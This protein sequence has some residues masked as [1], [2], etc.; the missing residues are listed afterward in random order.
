MLKRKS[1]RI[2]IDN[3]IARSAGGPEAKAPESI[4]CRDFL[5][6]VMNIC[7]KVVLTDDVKGEW[8]KHRSNFTRSWLVKMVSKKKAIIAGNVQNQELR[9]KIK[10]FARTDKQC[11]AMLKD[12]LLVEA[13]LATDKIVAARDDTVRNLL[14]EIADKVI[15]L[16][17]IIWVNPCNKDEQVIEWLEAGAKYELKRK[18]LKEG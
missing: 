7:H 10:H 3:S 1:K 17:Y 11:E 2:V 6:A 12:V 16:K 18:L 8:R 14:S 15:E 13:A 9:D 5:I 4:Y